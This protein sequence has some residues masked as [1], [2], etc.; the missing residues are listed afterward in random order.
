MPPPRRLRNAPRNTRPGRPCGV[1]PAVASPARTSS[2]VPSTMLL[3]LRRRPARG[4]AAAATTRR[5]T[6]SDGDGE[7]PGNQPGDAGSARGRRSEHDAQDACSGA[8][9][10]SPHGPQAL[11]TTCRV[12]SEWN[13]FP[14]ATRRRGHRPAL[15]GGTR[16]IRPQ[17]LEPEPQRSFCKLDQVPLGIRTPVF[18]RDRHARLTGR[19]SNSRAEQI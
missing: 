4:L 6:N 14:P 11:E 10:G 7:T 17:I 3:H 1:A 19:Q 18:R 13:R 12:G 9:C 2:T 5:G 8:T 16:A 15:F